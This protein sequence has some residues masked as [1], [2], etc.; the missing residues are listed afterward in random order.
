[1]VPQVVEPDVFLSQLDHDGF[2]IVPGVLD[3]VRV[4]AVLRDLAAILQP[5]QEATAIRSREGTVYAARNLLSLWPPVADVWRE[6]PLP[7]LLASV[8]G[9]DFGL[10]RVLF[11]D[12]P[13]ESTWALP[14][15]KDL[16]IAVRDNTLLSMQFGKP[17]TKVGVPHVEAPQVLL[18]NML[19]VR[20]HLDPMREEN[21]PLR[22]LPGSHRTGKRLRL[23]LG[24]PQTLHVG[25]GDVLLVR[26]L[27]AHCSTASYPGTRL[28]RRVLHLE[29]AGSPRLP[30]GYAW[31]TF[32]PGCRHR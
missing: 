1:M 26:P 27:V 25:R 2:T 7:G 9:P 21:G 23:D 6:P 4:D 15:H 16:V 8:L 20:I 17:T 5:E 28:H 19:T 10:V 24:K 18:E 31:H 3:A 11:F 30:D 12:K 32:L 13:P 14:W 29:F 22:V